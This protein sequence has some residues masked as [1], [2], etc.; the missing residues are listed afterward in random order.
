MIGHPKKKY[1][2]LI[3]DFLKHGFI[4]CFTTNPKVHRMGQNVK[5]FENK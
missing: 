4:L 5:D 2:I 1:A 3:S